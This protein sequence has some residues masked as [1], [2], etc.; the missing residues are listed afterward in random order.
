LHNVAGAGV[1]GFGGD[2]RSGDL[3]AALRDVADSNNQR[4]PQLTPAGAISTLQGFGAIWRRM[5]R[6]T[7]TLPAAP[8]SSS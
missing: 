1:A 8:T 4:T 7:S 3:V 2:A 6:V 5:T